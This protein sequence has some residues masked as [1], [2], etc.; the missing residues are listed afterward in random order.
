VCIYGLLRRAVLCEF[1]NSLCNYTAGFIVERVSLRLSEDDPSIFPIAEHISDASN[2][3]QDTQPRV[4][5]YRLANSNRRR[6]AT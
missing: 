6:E 1:M 5:T 4:R 3:L 2:C